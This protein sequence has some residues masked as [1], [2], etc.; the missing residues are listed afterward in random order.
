[1]I[2]IIAVLCSL[3]AP[4]DCHETVVTSDEVQGLTMFDCSNVAAL[5]KWMEGRPGQR[6]A[7]WKCQLGTRPE[8]SGA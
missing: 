7:G 2:K 6:L 1:M 4:S 8:R 3:S 5:A